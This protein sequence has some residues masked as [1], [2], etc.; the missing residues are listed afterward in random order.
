[1]TG[2][3]ITAQTTSQHGIPIGYY[4]DCD[5]AVC[6]D[7]APAGFEAGDYS[8]W[9]GFEGW[10]EPAAI[11]MDSE[12][13]SVT[14]CATCGRVIKHDLTSEGYA[15]ITESL[16]RA[17][18]GDIG[19]AIEQW[20]D[21]Y[22]DDKFGGG[23]YGVELPADYLSA[24][25]QGYAL[26]MLW[27][28]TRAE[29]DSDVDPNAWLDGND[30]EWAVSAFDSLDQESIRE[31]C[32]A[33]IRE[34]WLDLAQLPRSYGRAD[35]GRPDP[36]AV[37]ACAGHDFA[38]TR[39]GHGAGFWDRGL[40]ELGDRLTKAAHAYGASSAWCHADDDPESD[41]LAHLD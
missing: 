3:F 39:N 18:D 21:A 10:E 9:A 25:T 31:D 2:N 20:M 8:A 34:N 22:G 24:F 41:N 6:A 33:F 38:L 36:D 12:S 16:E 29:D 5:T 15:S 32:A 13:D 35:D 17:L 19:E 27:A 11:F 23:A 4:M 1:M 7:D 40:G 14:H 28:N 37:A 30:S 26:A